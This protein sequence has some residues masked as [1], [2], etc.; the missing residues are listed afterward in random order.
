M[1]KIIAI[2]GGPRKNWNTVNLL[3][4]T[5]DG[6]SSTGALTEMIHLYDLD[7]KGCSSC[8]S[9][10]K[11]ETYRDGKCAMRDGL[12]PVLDKIM[13][14]DAVVMGSP[15]Y[16]GDVTGAL[17][18]LWERLIFMN[19]AYDANDRFI[20]AKS[21]SCGVVYTMNVT[22]EKM[23]EL[24]YTKLFE[25]HIS[26]LKALNGRVEYLTA[27]DTF[28]FD[29]YSK[30]HAPMFSETSK[31]KSRLERFPKDADK[32]FSMGVKLMEG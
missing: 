22:E 11:A 10:K 3:Q 4:K 13:E 7:Y 1:K 32:A 14:S 24:G 9:C 27:C 8:F 31:K 26:F 12:S 5:L 20:T 16:L 21:V 25:S 30:Y 17:R 19:L 29:D 15:I 2:N 6:A 28:Q 18:S 23:K